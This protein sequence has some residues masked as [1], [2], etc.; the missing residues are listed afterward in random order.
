MNKLYPLKFKPI[1]K[2][3]IWGGNKIQSIMNMDFAPL[4]NCGEA[5]VLSGVDE[6]ETEILNGWLTGNKLNEIVEIYMGDLVGE[7]IFL[8]FGN[9]FPILV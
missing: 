8:R 1:F 5:W 2:D 4:P 3:K 9:E 7:K 6:N